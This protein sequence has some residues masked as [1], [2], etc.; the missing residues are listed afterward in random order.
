MNLY[1]SSLTEIGSVRHDGPATAKRI[2]DLRQKVFAKEQPPLSPESLGALPGSHLDQKDWQA[3]LDDGTITLQMPEQIPDEGPEPD[4]EAALKQMMMIDE[5]KT[6]TVGQTENYGQTIIET[7]NNQMKSH[8]KEL[9]MV[10]SNDIRDL[11]NR[12]DDHVGGLTKKL[13]NT[14]T[15]ARDTQSE[16]KHQL[17]ETQETV[18]YLIARLPRLIRNL[19]GLAMVRMTISFCQVYGHYRP[20]TKCPS[21]STSLGIGPIG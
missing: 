19:E 15:E 17:K 10:I 20:K 18:N 13:H 21:D 4:T 2:I 11:K 16:F 7:M 12:F 5:A 14:I 3:L 8:L 9:S 6:V 1:T